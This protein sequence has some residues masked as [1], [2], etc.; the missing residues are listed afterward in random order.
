MSIKLSGFR[1]IRRQG[2]FAWQHPADVL[3][4]DLD[5]TDMSDKQFEVAVREVAA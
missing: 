2:V 3:A 4:S 1:Y 5:C